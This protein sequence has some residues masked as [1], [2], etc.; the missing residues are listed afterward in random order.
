VE[1]EQL[2]K[3]HDL[4]LQIGNTRVSCKYNDLE[5]STK[6][7][8]SHG[9]S[10]LSYVITMIAEKRPLLFI[11]VPGFFLILIGILLGIYTLQYYNTTHVFLIPHAILVSIFLIIGALAVLIG[12][13]L[14]I[15]PSMLRRARENTP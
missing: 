7:P 4:G 5:T 11:S 8:T 15:I 6:T 13:I 12:L 14:N 2:I 3:A 9:I 1:S 10:V